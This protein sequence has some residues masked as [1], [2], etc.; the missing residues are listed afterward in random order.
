MCR[1]DAKCLVTKAERKE[2][3]VDVEPRYEHGQ[4]VAAYLA[5]YVRGGPLKN[6]RLLPFDKKNVTFRVSRKGEPWEQRTL[7]VKEFIRRILWH[8][9]ETGYRVVRA[10][11]LYHHH[12]REQLEA[13]REQLGGGGIP[14]DAERPAATGGEEP[15]DEQWLLVEDYCRI[16]G[17]LLETKT[18]PRAPPEAE[19]A[20]APY[21]EPIP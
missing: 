9:P 8:V 21:P 1:F 18:V 15:S 17:C 4:G 12:H 6:S 14:D 3:I 2:W 10:C 13:C 5:N 16:C 11:G 19:P 7:T 20:P